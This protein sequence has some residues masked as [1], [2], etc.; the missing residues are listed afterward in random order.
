MR[1]REGRVR[2]LLGIR[3]GHERSPADMTNDTALPLEALDRAADQAPC[4]PEMDGEIALGRQAVAGAE[5]AGPHRCAQVA[6]DAFLPR[7]R[8]RQ[9]QE[10]HF[11][12]VRRSVVQISCSRLCHDTPERMA[13][14]S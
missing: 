7:S 6:I 3:R 2:R 10:G 13:G 11:G 9:L 5:L 12:R 14:L 8:L 4:R 1:K